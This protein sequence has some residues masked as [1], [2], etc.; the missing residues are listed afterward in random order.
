MGQAVVQEREVDEARREQ[1]GR[2]ARIGWLDH[3]KGICI[4]LVVMLYATEVAADRAGHEGW[5]H[6]VA[7][8]AKP[9]RMPDFFLLSGLLLPLVIKRDWRL[10]LDRKVVHFAWFYVLWLTI[11][12]AFRSQD[13]IA[14]EG[15]SGAVAKY[16]VSYVEPYSMLWFI[17]MLPVFFVLTKLLQRA[18]ALLVWAAAAGLQM[19]QPDTGIKV[20]EKFN[21]YYVFFFTGYA[22]SGRLFGAVP[23]FAGH[24]GV[25]AL[26]LGAWAALNGYLVFGGYATLPG[27]NLALALAGCFAVMVFAC[28]VSRARAFRWLAYCGEHSI[29]IYLAF[30]IPLV[31]SRRLLAMAGLADVGWLSLLSTVAGV[32]G[33]LTLYWLVRG[34]RLAFL[35]RRPAWFS[36][37]RD[38]APAPEGEAARSGAAAS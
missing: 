2:A 9:F 12:F 29:V 24:H 14:K 1:R 23:R 37:V 27:L 22:L 36:I 8:F 17:Y 34:T 31:V 30:L 26:F 18:P 38:R 32:L 10:Y 19:W 25:A 20:I 15:L 4:I 6:V 35:F 7:D 11:L 5:L 13:V 16:L 28:W 33:A 3:A 21:A